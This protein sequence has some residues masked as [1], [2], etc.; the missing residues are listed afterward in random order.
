MVTV[1]RVLVV[2][3]HPLFREGLRRILAGR[4]DIE[5]VGVAEDGQQAVEQARAQQPD[6]VL[7]DVRMPGMDGVAA[8]RALREAAPGARVVMLTVSERDEDLFGAIKAG[9]RGYLL[10]SVQEEQLVEAIRQVYRGDAVLSPPLATRLLEELAR[11][12]P[13]SGDAGGLTERE[14]EIL[15]LASE[16][17]TNREIAQHLHLSVHT[18]KTHIRHVLDKLHAR[19]R[20]EAAVRA[21]QQ[22][23][24]PPAP[25]SRD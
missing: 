16:G 9:A 21:A 11:Q 3:D 17:W 24:L 15:R 20:A 10:K 22:G 14:R 5:V 19:N 13:A 12:P 23:Q 7:M 2:D 1:I 25:R 4:P 18:V 6:V 8:T